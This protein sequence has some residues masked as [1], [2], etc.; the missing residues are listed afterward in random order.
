MA[1]LAFIAPAEAQNVELVASANPVFFGQGVTLTATVSPAPP[2]GTVSFYDGVTLLAT[3]TLKSGQASFSTAL[4]TAGPHALSAVFGAAKTPVL[5][6]TVIGLPQN[7]FAAPVNYPAGASVNGVAAA[8]FN[9]DGNVDLAVPDTSGLGV[10]VLLG[11]GA[12]GFWPPQIFYTGH[13]ATALSI[14]DLDGDGNPDVVVLNKDEN[15]VTVLLGDGAGSFLNVTE[16]SIANPP[17]SVAIADFDQDGC[18]D[19]ALLAENGYVNVLPGGCDGTFRNPRISPAGDSPAWLALGDFNH[20]GQADLAVA[21]SLPFGTVTVLLGNGDGSFQKP[22]PYAA[23]GFPSFVA[24]ADLDGDGN[25]DLIASNATTGDVSVLLGNGDGSFKPAAMYAAGANPGPIAVGDFDGDGRLDLAVANA[26]QGNITVLAGAGNGTFLPPVNYSTSGRSLAVVAADFNG[27][28][29]VDLAVADSSAASLL[30]GIVIYRDQTI[31]VAPIGG[32]AV[33]AIASSGLPVSLASMT[34]Q[35]CTVSGGVVSPVS[36]GTCSIVATQSGNPMFAP[37][38]PVTVSF[39][40]R[41]AQT[42][43][44]AAPAPVPFLTPPFQLSASASSGLPVTFASNTP[45]VCGV[46]NSTMLVILTAGLCSVTASQN[47]SA[48][49]AP[50]V[51]VTQFFPIV[52]AP[53]T[54][55]FFAPADVTPPVAPFGVAASTSS[56]LAV[57]LTSGTPQVCT[58]ANSLVT[59]TGAGLC[60]L[61]ASQSGTQNYSPAVPVTRTFT[62]NEEALV[63]PHLAAGGAYTSVICALN[64]ANQPARFSAAFRDDNGNPTPLAITGTGSVNSVST[65]IPVRGMACYEASSPNGSTISASAL[66]TADP[67]VTVQ[68]LFRNASADGH[69]YE[70]SVASG[71]GASELVMPFDATT[72]APTGAPIYTG[73]AI[74]N[75]DN[76]QPANVTCTARDEDGIVISGAVSIPQLQ[77]GGHWA[78]YQFPALSGLRGT[79]DCVS[80]TKMGMIGLRFLGA[81]AFSSLPVTPPGSNAASSLPHFAA[82]GGWVTGL[83]VMNTAATPGHFTMSFRNDRGSP[84]SLEVAG[85]GAVNAISGVVPGHGLRYYEASSPDGSTIG[86]SAVLTLDAGM[87]I[88]ALFRNRAADGTYYEAS[89]PASSGSNEFTIPFDGS[90]FAPTGDPMLTGIAIANM[91]TEQS[92]AVTC[93]ARDESGNVVPGALP[94]LTIAA[95]GHWADYRFPALSGRK[96]TIDCASG[97]RISAIGLRFLGDNAFSSTPVILQ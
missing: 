25:T 29:R 67:G 6:Q 9:G 88:Q 3:R 4:L 86:G 28:Y 16:V 89:V 74:A 69:Y 34:P 49:F 48:N 68:S 37:A 92:A 39:P 51:P 53:Q 63:A 42:I 17:V 76:S 52:T 21:N 70:A 10:D 46:A 82:G 43:S 55:T 15:V 14:A 24:A 19:L 47:G 7:G 83:F 11:N 80:N 2:R 32:L 75:M 30:P 85:T 93:I 5:Q 97:N 94:A 91:D 65:T 71:P 33:T 58:V 27:D 77:P 64:A 35:I 78:G 57:L 13:A 23:H 90:T 81:G 66:A 1:A 26:N 56:G 50:A 20:D 12:S 38:T 41:Q 62:V 95:G 8:D 87:V 73:L 59:I 54:I 45:Q 40:V 79:L 31:T 72:F 61:T 18:P 22:T 96:G 84:V 60:S 36:A 44:F